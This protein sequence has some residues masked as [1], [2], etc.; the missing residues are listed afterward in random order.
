MKLLIAAISLA[1]SVAINAEEASQ[2]SMAPQA[3]HRHF[4]TLM[5]L[6]L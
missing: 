2:S 1:L 3:A 4:F 6:P 5:E